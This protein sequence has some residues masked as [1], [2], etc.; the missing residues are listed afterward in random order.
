MRD[1]IFFTQGKDYI[2]YLNQIVLWGILVL[3]AVVSLF[4]VQLA[5]KGQWHEDFLS[6]S[7]SKAVLGIAAILIV[8]HHLAQLMANLEM[9]QGPFAYLEYIGVSLVGLFFFFSGYGLFSSKKNR[10]DYFKGF[11]KK[12]LVTVLV[13][14]YLIIIIFVI[15]ALAMGEPMTAGEIVAYLTGWW[16]L[17]TQM[18][19][20]VEIAIFYVAFYLIFKNVKNDKLGL[21]L[22]GLFIGVFVVTSILIGHGAECECDKWLQGEWWFNTSF[23]FLIGMIFAHNEENI[24]SFMKKNY[25]VILLI[26][27]LANIGFTIPTVNLVAEGYYYCEY[28]EEFTL[29]MIFGTKLMVLA[30]QFSMVFFFDMIVLMLMMKIKCRNLVLD[31][32]GKISLVLYLSHNIFLINFGY[33]QV[34][35]L[36]E[37]WMLVSAS[38]ICAIITAFILQI[39]VNA[40]TKLLL[41][42]K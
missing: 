12:R 39:P 22:M 24:V 35:N 7:S 11:L 36:T 33:L 32:L 8:F 5:K 38:I 28:A 9:D 29:P 3:L 10:E 1:I 31:K 6:L 26:C 30:L 2:M 40:I 16:L 14:F 37:P 13:P 21:F 23:M 19:F 18:W 4:K 15:S 20:V 17:N 41:K 27:I 42:K 25:I 34:G